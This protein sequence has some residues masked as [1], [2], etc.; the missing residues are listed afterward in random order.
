MKRAVLFLTMV[1]MSVIFFSCSS[2]K[3]EKP[4]H[5]SDYKTSAMKYMPLNIGNKWKYQ[6]NYFGSSGVV[7]IQITATDGDWFIDNKGGR[8]KCDKRGVRDDDR[9]LLMFPL[10]REPWVSII[11]NKTREL[12]STEGVDESVIVPAGKFDG[13]VKVHTVVDLPEGKVLHS[14]HYFV[15]DVGIVKIQTVMEDVKEGKTIPQTL[16]ELVEYTINNGKN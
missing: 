2:D 9:Y 7:D 14:Y 1:L 15:A 11:N 5:D 8:L 12:R 6:V 3:K 13:A 16:T 10:Q 4:M